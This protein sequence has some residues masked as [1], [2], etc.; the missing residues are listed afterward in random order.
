MKNKLPVEGVGLVQI[1]WMTV[2]VVRMVGAAFAQLFL[3]LEH[4]VLLTQVAVNV[5]VLTVL[6]VCSQL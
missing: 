4:V 1:K 5:P 2:L 3:I 6:D